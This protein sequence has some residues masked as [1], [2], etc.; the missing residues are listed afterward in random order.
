MDT[1]QDTMNA[2]AKAHHSRMYSANLADLVR[3]VIPHVPSTQVDET[4]QL[5]NAIAVIQKYGTAAGSAFPE[6]I[7]AL[8][9]DGRVVYVTNS[10]VKSNFYAKSVSEVRALLESG[11]AQTQSQINNPPLLA[12]NIPT[13][14]GAYQ[15]PLNE[16]LTYQRALIARLD[17]L[18]AK[19]SP[20][21]P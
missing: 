13:E 5:L 8:T 3:K 14:L 15:R 11:V 10:D 9:N 2:M 20:N 1:E 21:S 16:M 18:V 17:G 4:L 6:Q 12:R 19:A 7:L